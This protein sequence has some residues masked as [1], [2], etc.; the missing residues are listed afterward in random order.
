MPPILVIARLTALET[1]RRKLLLALGVL[2]L[3]VIGVSAWGFSK[4]W[5]IQTNGGPAPPALVRTTAS[6]L[7]ILVAFMFEAI[8]ALSA[9]IVAA[10]SISTD[11]ESGLAL[12]MLARPIRRSDFLLGK[13]LGLAAMLVLY[14][15]V[16]AWGELL[17]VE[18]AT[19]F[20][21]PHPILLV[22]FIAT[23]GLVLLTLS[24]ALSTRLSGITGAVIALGGYFMAWVGGIVGGIGSAL[25]N[26]ALATA[27]TISKLLLPTDGLWRGAVWTL[28]PEALLVTY[29]SAGPGAAAFPFAAA[30]PPPAPFLAWSALWL[31]AMLGIALWSFRRREI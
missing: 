17:A 8:L 15:A 3:V 20:F 10:P 6:Q 19:G 7:L 1:S 30:N 28:E 16:S 29:R 31:L 9:A 18:W 4:L 24:L 26:D 27:G 22:V 5:D 11:L 25:H 12:S 14:T 21:P 23:V 13:W 2:T